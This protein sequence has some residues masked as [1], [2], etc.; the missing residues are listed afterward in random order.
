MREAMTEIEW[1]SRWIQLKSSIFKWRDD[2]NRCLDSQG[3]NAH[4]LLY[5]ID[6]A[7]V[8]E[9]KHLAAK[10]QRLHV[11]SEQNLVIDCA[12]VLMHTLP[13]D[14]YGIFHRPFFP[15]TTVIQRDFNCFLNRT[16]PIRQSWFYLLYHRNLLDKGYVSF[17]MHQK[18]CLWYPSINALETFDYYHAT[19]LSS[20]DDIKEDIKKI[21]PYKNFVDEDNLLPIILSTK[22][23]II[24]ETYFERTDCKVFSEKT[25]R[26]IQL[27]RPWL[28]FA[29]TGCVEKLR[30]MGFDV[31]DDY[32]DHSYDVYD[33]AENCVARQEG[34]L[35]ES[36]RL[37]QLKITDEILE[38]WNHKS[39]HNQKIM[40]QWAESWQSKCRAVFDK[41]LQ[42]ESDNYR[43][44]HL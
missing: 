23:S 28:L 36:V 41:I 22:F 29:A 24:V 14:F 16:D 7:N 6:A 27:P 42:I 4:V 32:V 13:F 25:W 38:D 26:A 19:T 5:L 33:T 9:I 17:N 37:T 12:N 21:V 1:E 3:S 8:D 39:K 31:F 30:Q 10:Y 35:S 18:P 2:T 43:S 34:I 11:V 20:F 15:K 44:L 40:A